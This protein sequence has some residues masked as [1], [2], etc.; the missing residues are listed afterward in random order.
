M[1]NDTGTN[2]KQLENSN[3]TDGISGTTSARKKQKW[4]RSP[5]KIVLLIIIIINCLNPLWFI[6][7][8]IEL[9]DDRRLCALSLSRIWTNGQTDAARAPARSIHLNRCPKMTIRIFHS[10]DSILNRCSVSKCRFSSVLKCV[11]S[12][13]AKATFSGMEML[14]IRWKSLWLTLYRPVSL[15]CEKGLRI[16]YFVLIAMTT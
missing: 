16:Y 6:K 10:F 7:P 3:P 9:K 11:F 13:C 12:V 1:S 8:E 15:T 14:K 2:R 5:Q 4:A